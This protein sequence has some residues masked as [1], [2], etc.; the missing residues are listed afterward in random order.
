MFRKNQ[1]MFVFTC[2]LVFFILD[3]IIK[4]LF[5][6]NLVSNNFLLSYTEN[7]GISFGLQL[8]GVFLTLFYII[9]T[10]IFITL[11][12]WL[13]KSWAHSKRLEASMVWLVILGSASNIIDRLK[14]GFV[15]DYINL[16]FWPVFNIGDI[17]IMAGVI[18]LFINH[19]KQT[20]QKI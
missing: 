13:I 2:G 4:Y 12:V 11:I 15:V 5:I 6:N 18:I 3:R 9:I 17:M 8:P 7:S 16:H 19:Y 14:F 20:Q 1:P 10:L